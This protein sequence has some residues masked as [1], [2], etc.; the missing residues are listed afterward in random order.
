[1][2]RY[3]NVF[4]NVHG[5]QGFGIR[6]A[7]FHPLDLCTV[8]NLA[9]TKTYPKNKSRVFHVETTWKRPFPRRFNVEYTWCVC[10]VF[11]T[12]RHVTSYW[13]YFKYHFGQIQIKCQ[14]RFSYSG[15]SND[16]KS[17][18]VSYR[19]KYS[20]MDQENFGKGSL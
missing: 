20:R 13:S 17:K 1:M 12:T 18:A 15:E 7:G 3:L 14:R 11:K 10:R 2:E 16:S 4:D 9:I 8:V 5:N 19:T 6:N